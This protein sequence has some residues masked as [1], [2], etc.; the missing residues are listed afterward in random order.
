M[1]LNIDMLSI[2]FWYFKTKVEELVK[3]HFLLLLI[4]VLSCH[5]SV[6]NPSAFSYYGQCH[7]LLQLFN[8]RTL[9]L[10]ACLAGLFL[11]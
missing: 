1:T 2:V 11:I 6:L 9:S 7:Y 3:G 8:L 4:L 10:I 5:I